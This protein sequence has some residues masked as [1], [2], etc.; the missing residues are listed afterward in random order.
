METLATGIPWVIVNWLGLACSYAVSEGKANVPLN[1]E[2]ELSHSV[3][4]RN[5]AP[6]F[7]ICFPWTHEV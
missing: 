5:L 3:T 7:K 6:N 2:F 4:S 1:P